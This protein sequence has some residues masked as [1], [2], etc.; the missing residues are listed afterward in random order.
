MHV[1]DWFSTA[2]PFNKTRQQTKYPIINNNEDDHE[3]N[4][5]FPENQ[6]TKSGWSLLFKL[7]D[8]QVKLGD[9]TNYACNSPSLLECLVAFKGIISLWFV[10]LGSLKGYKQVSKCF[11]HPLL[12]RTNANFNDVDEMT[13]LF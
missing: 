7:H 10:A 6:L 5:N 4:C 9:V 11:V 3:T 1:H 13:L 2:E 12:L 8:A